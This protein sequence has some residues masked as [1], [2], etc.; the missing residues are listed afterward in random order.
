MKA[1][2]IGCV[3]HFVFLYEFVLLNS[4]MSDKLI[5]REAPSPQ[6]LVPLLIQSNMLIVQP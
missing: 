3:I 6:S 2:C 1:A 5:V 4:P